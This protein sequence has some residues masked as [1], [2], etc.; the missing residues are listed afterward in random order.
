MGNESLFALALM[1]GLVVA[2]SVAFA[3]LFRGLA[4]GLRS[5]TSLPYEPIPVIFPLIPIERTPGSI[6]VGVVTCV[7]GLA[8]VVVIVAWWM[9]GWFLPPS[10][11]NF[12]S[13]TY[14]LLFGAITGLGGLLI[15]LCQPMGRKCV[16]WG[17][18]L[19]LLPA[20]LAFAMS[21]MLP[22]FEK[23][24]LEFRQMARTVT[25][26]MAGHVV[27]DLLLGYLAQK[28]GLPEGWQP[29][30]HDEPMPRVEQYAADPFN[31]P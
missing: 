8:H 6:A 22:D 3:S 28:V 23:A 9:T 25:Y 31:M 19:L 12:V 2:V 18:M 7:Y 16:S 20:G 24:T 30:S 13:G 14:V 11:S 29:V 5:D 17:L 15:M 27:V 21:L 4:R 26:L 1:F 10:G